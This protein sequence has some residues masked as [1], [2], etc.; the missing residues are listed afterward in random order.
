VKAFDLPLDAIAIEY[1]EARKLI[2]G[3]PLV[4]AAR[5]Y[6]RHHG[7]GIKRK[8]V[9]EAVDEMIAVKANKK[10]PVSGTY[11]ADL[12]YRLGGFKK[13]FHCDVNAL[14]PDDVAAWFDSLEVSARSH[15]NFFKTLRTFLRYAQRHGWLSKETDLLA[16]VEIEGKGTASVEIFT[17]KELTALLENASA[18]AATCIALGA[19]AGLR[20]E[21]ILRLDWNDL[22]RSPGFIEVVARKAKTATRRIVPIS[23]NLSYWLAIAPR[24]GARVWPRSK[25][26]FFKAFRRT[27]ASAK[28]MWKHNALRHSFISYRLAE[29]K[30]DNQVALEAGN[31]PR[32][33]HEN[34]K[35]LVTPEQAQTWFAIAPERARNIVPIRA[36]RSDQ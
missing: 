20:S 33:I 22:E 5:F 26:N 29:V 23:D 25:W 28:I 1:S 16:R 27:A 6:A 10:K 30:N 12:R 32:M 3:V 21:E 15:D 7:H 35:A 19:F 36:A 17:S 24:N 31:S 14:T 34:Y 4:D 11:L 18:E 9:A 8:P 2:D 13:A